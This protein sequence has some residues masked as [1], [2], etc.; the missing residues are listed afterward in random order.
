[1]SST[2]GNLTTLLVIML[3]VDVILLLGNI[4]IDDLNPSGQ[5]YF[6]YD[7]SFIKDVDTGDYNLNQTAYNNVIPQTESGITTEGNLFTDIFRTVKGWFNPITGAWNYFIRF[8]GGP[9]SY[10][11]D[12][13][14]PSVLVFAIGSLWYLLTLFL[15]MSYLFGRG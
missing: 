15:L 5:D 6:R 11:V 3:M 9:V 7:Q 1:M 8:L 12:I 4:A 13:G 14:A 10:L 2:T